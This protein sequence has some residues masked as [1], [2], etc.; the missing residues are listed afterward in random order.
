MKR[1]ISSALIF[2]FS[3]I[4]I[5]SDAPRLEYVTICSLYGA[6]WYY[7]P[8]SD[9][10]IF[11]TTGETRKQT[12]NGTQV[13]MSLLAYRVSQLENQLQQLIALKNRKAKANPAAEQS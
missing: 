2:L 11:P 7:I 5:A 8:G 10:C 6:G 1:A 12:Q 9:I 4:A 13:G 3:S